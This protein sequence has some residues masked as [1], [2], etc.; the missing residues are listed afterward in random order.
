MYLYPLAV[1]QTRNTDIEQNNK[2]E[3]QFGERTFKK[4]ITAAFVLT[5]SSIHT[6]FEVTIHILYFIKYISWI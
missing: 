4:W 6:R 1:V 5:Q 3:Y 2:N